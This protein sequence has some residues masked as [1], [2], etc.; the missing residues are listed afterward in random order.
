MVLLAFGA[1]A[2]VVVAIVRHDRQQ[3]ENRAAVAEL[4]ARQAANAKPRV[5]EV[6]PGLSVQVT[7]SMPPNAQLL[8]SKCLHAFPPSQIHTVPTYDLEG[9]RYVGSYLCDEHWKAAL[10]ETRARIMADASVDEVGSMLE[11]LVRRGV[12]KDRLRTFTED[13]SRDEAALA[14]LDALERGRLV[15]P[16]P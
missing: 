2:L 16:L 13:R 12:T 14:V 10:A 5:L 15:V 3:A 6:A 11:V 7:S 1:A 4:E 8:C 9:G